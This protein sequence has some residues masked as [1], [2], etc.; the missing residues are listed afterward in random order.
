MHNRPGLSAWQA[1]G[2]IGAAET[3]GGRPRHDSP[4]PFP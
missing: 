2:N 1:H 4:K 3:I